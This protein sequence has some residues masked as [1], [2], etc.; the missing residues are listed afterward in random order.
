MNF[1]NYLALAVAILAGLLAL[2]A[3]LRILV[4]YIG[5]KVWTGRGGLQLNCL[6]AAV[7]APLAI[8]LVDVSGVTG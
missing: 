5:N 1:W 7:C 4:V 6:Q 3:V 2:V 8:W